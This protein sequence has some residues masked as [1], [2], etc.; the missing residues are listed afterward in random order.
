MFWFYINE[1]FCDNYCSIFCYVNLSSRKKVCIPFLGELFSLGY[2]VI[3]FIYLSIFI[4]IYMEPLYHN[5][6]AYLYL[7]HLSSR[8][9]EYI[10]R[11]SSERTIGITDICESAISRG[12]APGTSQDMELKVILFMKEM[13]YLLCNGFAVNT[14]YFMGNVH[15]NG[16]FN[17]VDE[18]YDPE[19]HTIS[20]SFNQ[21]E[22]LRQ[23]LRNLHLDVQGLANNVMSI[24]EVVDIKTGTVNGI[25]T[26]NRNLKIKGSKLKI[27][28]NGQT[29]VYLI[30]QETGNRIKIDPSDIVTN[31]PSELMIALPDIVAGTY[32][33]EVVTQ[34]TGNALLKEPRSC[35]FSEVLRVNE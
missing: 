11:I 30:H 23:E 13:A 6:K 17:S 19:K 33:V 9:N 35:V 32:Q 4:I 7:N 27:A 18:Q 15:I 25:I 20:I 26:P 3:D 31:H 21:G 14:G 34:F 10:A 29:G 16:V 1:W 22:L 28:G 8:Q 5:I 2:P 24:S 12:G